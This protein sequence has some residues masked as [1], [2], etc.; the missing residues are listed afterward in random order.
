MIKLNSLKNKI[1]EILRKKYPIKSSFDNITDLSHFWIKGG[2]VDWNKYFP[3]H[4]NIDGLILDTNYAKYK[5]IKVITIN[6]IEYSWKKYL[7][8]YLSLLNISFNPIVNKYKFLFYLHLYNNID[9]LCIKSIGIQY[10]K[11]KD[12]INI[13]YE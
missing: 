1:N 4:I 12:I 8:L 13:N 6:N 2:I 3:F 5:I 7:S 10:K 11:E 9:E